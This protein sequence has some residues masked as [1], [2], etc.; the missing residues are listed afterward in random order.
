MILAVRFSFLRFPRR[1]NP[2]FWMRFF[3]AVPPAVEPYLLAA[4][5]S[6]GSPGGGTPPFGCFPFSGSPGGGTPPFGCFPFSRLPR[7]WN[8]TFWMR[9]FLAVPPAVEPHL[10][11]AFLSRGS[12]GGGTLPF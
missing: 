1:W 11:D 5:L 8:P 2:T 7:R 4:F 9:F 3:L 6:R 10:L 12:P